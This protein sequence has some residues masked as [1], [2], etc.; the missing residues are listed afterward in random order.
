MHKPLCISTAYNQVRTF[1]ERKQIAPIEGISDFFVRVLLLN[2][3]MTSLS[4]IICVILVTFAAARNSEREK[5]RE[6]RERENSCCEADKLA[7]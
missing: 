3:S 4:Y 7:A 5:E 6:K 1:R 2:V